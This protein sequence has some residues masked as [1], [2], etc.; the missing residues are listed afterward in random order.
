MS[1]IIFGIISAVVGFL[2]IVFSF[3][4]MLRNKKTDD[5]NEGKEDGMILTELGYIKA[6]VDDLKIDNRGIRND[7][8]TL[9]ER[10]TR[11]EESCK[12]AHKRINDL[13][14]YHEPN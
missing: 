14:K 11:N 7:M 3:V 5:K 4:V 10:V 13:A 9:H 8:Q 2:G 6:G 12:Q 1:D